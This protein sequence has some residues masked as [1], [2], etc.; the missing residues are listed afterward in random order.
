[1]IKRLTI[2]H[3]TDNGRLFTKT[4]DFVAV[5]IDPDFH[6]R[7]ERHEAVLFELT[8]G[9][10]HRLLLPDALSTQSVCSW[11]RSS[12]GSVFEL[13]YTWFDQSVLPDKEAFQLMKETGLAKGIIL[14]TAYSLPNR[15]WLSALSLTDR[16]QFSEQHL[17]L[18]NLAVFVRCFPCPHKPELLSKLQYFKHLITQ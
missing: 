15:D 11:L 5:S 12:T 6:V 9:E 3:I 13:S 4:V 17:T 7:G 14:H 16:S 1:M 2:Q 18:T 8:N 10:V